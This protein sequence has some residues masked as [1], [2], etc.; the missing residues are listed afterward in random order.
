MATTAKKRLFY[1]LILCAV[2]LFALALSLM[3]SRILT[4]IALEQ[5]AR[6]G[7]AEHHHEESCYIGDVL[8]CAQKAHTHA[9]NCYLIRL[10]DND[11][12]WMLQMLDEADDKSLE[13]VVTGLLNRILPQSGLPLGGEVLLN[14][15]DI[16]LLNTLASAEASMSNLVF[17][18][19]LDNGVT[20]ALPMAENAAT[21]SATDP[22]TGQVGMYIY[23]DGGWVCLGTLNM[24]NNAVARSAIL[25]VYKNQTVV[26][27][28][29]LNNYLYYSTTHPTN[30]STSTAPY[31]VETNDTNIAFYYPQNTARHFFLS[32]MT[33]GGN[34]WNPK[35]YYNPIN[36]YTVTL[37]YSQSGASVANQVQYVQSGEDSTLTPDFDNYLWYTAEEN[38]TQVT[39]ANV[40]NYLNN[41]DGKTTLYAKPR[42]Y[43]V[44]Y[45]VNGTVVH[46][47]S[48]SQSNAASYVIGKNVTSPEGYDAWYDDAAGTYHLFTASDAAKTIT[49]T[50]NK[51]FTAVKYVTA[52]FL[53][54][55]GNP[56][57][58]NQTVLQGQTITLPQKDGYWW[59]VGDVAYAPGSTVELTENTDFK[60]VPGVTVT[61]DYKTDSKDNAATVAPGKY[62]LPTDIGADNVWLGSDGKI[63]QGGAE[64]ELL[65]DM[66]FTESALLTINYEGSQSGSVI[67]PSDTQ[68]VAEGQSVRLYTMNPREFRT[69]RNIT[70]FNYWTCEGQNYA[71]GA[72]LSWEEL[73]TLAGGEDELTMTADW[74]SSNTG[75]NQEYFAQFYIRL[76]SRAVDYTDTG[77]D[78]IGN[79]DSQDYSDLVY[80]TH[81]G[82]DTIDTKF[83]VVDSKDNSFGADQE[84]RA[85]EGER[86]SGM[87]LYQVPSDQ[88]VLDYLKNNG[89]GTN[90]NYAFDGTEEEA[91]AHVASLGTIE[92]AITALNSEDRL[93]FIETDEN[94]EAVGLELVLK[95]ELDTNHY[96]V[97][98]YVL[99]NQDD[100]WHID[101]RLVKNEGTIR[102]TKTFQGDA[103]AMTAA[104]DGFYIEANCESEGRKVILKLDADEAVEGSGTETLTPVSVSADKLAYEWQ[105]KHVG[106]G[107]HWTVTEFISN[108]KNSGDLEAYSVYS[109]FSVYDSSGLNKA[110]K[111][112]YGSAVTVQGV[113]QAVDESDQHMLRADFTNFYL[114]KDSIALKKEDSATGKGLAG[115]KFEMFHVDMDEPLKFKGTAGSYQKDDN[116]SITQL[117]TDANGYIAISG[118]SYDRDEVV[119]REVGSSVP[120]GYIQAEDITLQGVVDAA[121]EL[122]DVKII[123]IGETSTDGMTQEK[124]HEDTEYYHAQK[125]LVIKNHAA[126]SISVTAQKEWDVEEALWTDTVTVELY[127]NGQLVT[128]VL[129]SVSPASVTLK[130][131]EGYTYTWEN[132][133]SYVDGEK[134]V[135]SIYE[136]RVGDEGRTLSGRFIN[137]LDSYDLP[138]HTYDD[139]GEL[140]NTK[141]TVSNDL[142]RIRLAIRKTDTSGAA[143][144]PGVTFELQSM[145]NS[146]AVNTTGYQSTLTTGE[147]GLLSFEGL[148]D[149]YYRLTETA[150][151]EGYLKPEEPVYIHIDISG[152]VSQ[153]LWENGAPVIGSD[154]KWSTATLSG[155]ITQQS[156]F[157]LLVKNHPLAPLPETGGAG[158]S[159]YTQS[160]L[161]LITAAAALYIY[162]KKRRKEER[163]SS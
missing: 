30:I 69:G 39:A 160:G 107:E 144:L 47:D 14:A 129:P 59:F 131:E 135:W 138:Q 79:N 22:A 163:Y 34:W 23:L 145:T 75:S 42:D 17:N 120:N 68:Y 83:Q 55:A 53:D 155:D 97:R 140:V 36:F 43:K 130:R 151:P 73:Q 28:A 10:R 35:Y 127:A 25:N 114:R 161:L 52:R 108:D 102:I 85:M 125:M 12:N 49:L 81:L 116:G 89:K 15:D 46:T 45:K 153:A 50:G 115:V 84:I 48:V 37:D 13:T 162:S 19:A 76:D 9:E 7:Q 71:P 101:G 82:G 143:P 51:S 61:L 3:G 94:G 8:V 6:C 93:Y 33:E 133:P 91:A 141:L 65:G 20:L 40:D 98:W 132:L 113:T 139:D 64:V 149:G 128:N 118:F 103:D 134:V 90:E 126:D 56:L 99:K 18:A 57:S 122:Q 112:E 87:W 72:L 124:I 136:T 96:T 111:A 62:K 58:G 146:G 154:G 77:G 54:G 70:Y 123:K 66:T 31:Q 86:S 78:N 38:G 4:S 148:A 80:T 121:G 16:L 88:F 32:E 11:L 41:I 27:D 119:F 44:T 159:M 110:Q 1:N 100:G 106:P 74:T 2:I 152:K 21:T 26:S 150:T 156:S 24:Q 105:V 157:Y 92:E 137:W 104:K 158:T 95:S 142:Y 29:T 147:N 63:Y 67:S 117:E 60:A 5:P 109:E